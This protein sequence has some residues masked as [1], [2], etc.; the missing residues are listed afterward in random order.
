ML[1]FK[2]NQLR[3]MG[4]GKRDGIVDFT[5]GFNLICGRSDTGKTWILKS[6]Y[7]LFGSSDIPIP[8]VTGYTSVQGIFCTKR[9]GLV[10][11][12]RG[13]GEKVATVLCDDPSI[14]SGEYATDYRLKRPRYLNDLWLRIIGINE[15]ISI[16]K[17]K[18]Y[19]RERLSW[20]NIVS[21]FF[22]DENEIDSADSV[23]A[24]D[25]ITKT[26]MLSSLIFLLSGD[27]KKDEA[28]ILK[29]KQRK[30]VK[31]TLDDYYTKRIESLKSERAGY[32]HALDAANFVSIDVA[33]G[34]LSQQSESYK[35]EIDDLIEENASIATQL[36]SLRDESINTQ[37]LIDRYESLISQYKADL[38][39]MGFILE[40]QHSL[41]KLPEN[42]VCQFCG[43]EVHAHNKDYEEAIVAETTRIVAEISVIAATKEE[44]AKDK[45]D[46]DDAI[47]TLESRNVDIQAS[48]KEKK[49]LVSN[50]GEAIYTFGEQASLQS[51]IEIIDQQISDLEEQKAKPEFAKKTSEPYSATK[52]LEKIVGKGFENCL[53]R[54]LIACNFTS[55]HATW[56]FTKVD[57]AIDNIPKELDQG[58]GYRSFLNSV[59]GLMIYEY[60]NK[61]SAA[62]KPGLL[63]VDTPLLG[64]DED[65]SGT[66][67][68]GLRTGL[69]K[70][71]ISHVADGQVIVVDN[72]DE[73][74]DLDF[75]EMGVNLIV[76]HKNDDEGH[77]YGF[78]PD[79]RKDIS[80]EEK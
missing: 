69:Y 80:K 58:K 74:P 33:I 19:E 38:L 59:V 52:E 2:I 6:I 1:N 4:P 26:A 68:T 60:F 17:N 24:K 71:F 62:Y 57:L 63:M 32:A 65:T 61:D 42:K 9:F 50:L 41:K 27:Y 14:E 23:I 10:T 35:K 16:P 5:D 66:K 3:A 37:V 43:G 44:V 36:A 78:L 12:T 20:T 15:T 18:D 73:L 40:G 22:L 51:K 79:W 54:I 21:A 77:I 11:I 34:N 25:N 8:E 29:D 46:I 49:Q 28:I 55:G 30:A 39:R 31:V 70:Y 53:N 67:D 13:V 45:S 47:R 75:S 76:Y 56:D 48:L 7:Y 72:L 64:F